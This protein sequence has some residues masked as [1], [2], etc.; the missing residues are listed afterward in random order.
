MQITF[1]V[2]LIFTFLCAFNLSLMHAAD[3]FD[4]FNIEPYV[5]T[6]STYVP[7]Y[8]T[9]DQNSDA[10]DDV[11]SFLNRS[12]SLSSDI[13]SLDTGEEMPEFRDPT[14]TVGPT[15]SFYNL[16]SS[17]TGISKLFEYDD[18]EIE[19][20]IN[21]IQETRENTSS[22]IS[23]TTSDLIDHQPKN[24]A[25]KVHIC[26]H[27]KC[28]HISIGIDSAAEHEKTHEDNATK[29]NQQDCLFKT[30]MKPAMKKH[31]LKYHPS[32]AIELL[33][34]KCEHPGCDFTSKHNYP[35]INNL[36]MSTHEENATGCTQPRCQFKTRHKA[37]M[38]RHMKNYHPGVLYTEPKSHK[39]KH[40]G[41]DFE[42]TEKSILKQHHTAT[43]ADHA[44]GCTQQNCPFKKRSQPATRQDILNNRSDILN[45]GPKYYKCEHQGCDST[46]NTESELTDHTK[47]HEENATGCT[48][49]HCTFKTNYTSAMIRHMK[50]YHARALHIEPKSHKCEHQGCD[51]T[52]DTESDL[53]DHTKT[54]EENAIPCDQ[55]D[56][57]FRSIFETAMETHK[58]N[59]HRDKEIDTEQTVSTETDKETTSEKT[60]DKKTF[61]CSVCGH[62]TRR[63]TNLKR[64]MRTHTKE[65]PFACE[66][67]DCGYTATENYN[68]QTHMKTHRDG[69]EAC[70]KEGCR[71]KTTSTRAMNEHLE[72]HDAVEATSKR[73]RTS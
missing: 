18:Y 31:I 55:P 35:S 67:P 49:P 40:Q 48:Q 34:F 46:F 6:Y 2:K 1:Y 44:T 45:A 27:P 47:A 4:F 14:E 71:F 13:F 3:P 60:R 20:I 8:S 61:A 39:C 37:D 12:E 23:V 65:R 51:S 22:S 43:H 28:G 7:T 17:D 70:N 69:A 30:T 53:T 73:Q 32:A 36:H 72:K 58:Q 19:D 54:H 16:L 56:C 26:N 29:C 24:R 41:C 63:S 38:N 62:I 25:R 15:D 9:I 59:H 5:P 52:F 68:L 11:F 21:D 57:Q 50:N 33:S 42:T 66:Y 64:H 10:E